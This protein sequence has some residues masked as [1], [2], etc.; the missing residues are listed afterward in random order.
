MKFVAS[1]GIVFAL[2]IVDY[3]FPHI[4]MDRWDSNWLNIQVS[5]HHPKGNWTAIA[6]C[7]TTFDVA[8]LA[9]WFEKSREAQIEFGAVVF[10]ESS[11]EFEIVGS[12]NGY[13][14]KVC[15]RHAMRPPWAWKDVRKCDVYVK[16]PL[17][18]IDMLEAAKALRAQLESYP[19]RGLGM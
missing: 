16:F 5:V 15:F 2:K 12:R 17:G 1:N 4:E 6:P 19:Q 3:E 14:L 7:M 9:N 18:E 10:L 11:V 13:F 8:R